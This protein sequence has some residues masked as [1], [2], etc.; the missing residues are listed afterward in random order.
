MY[1]FLLAIAL[2]MD[3]VAVCMANATK[4]AQIK[5]SSICLMAFIFGFFQA[6]MPVLGYFFGLGFYKFIAEIDHYIAF[7]ILVF[8]G[9]KM[10]KESKNHLEMDFKL[11]FWTLILG[12]IATS[13]DALAA[14]ITLGFESVNIVFAAF[15]IGVVCFVLCIGAGLIGKFLGQ[16]LQNKALILGGVILIILGFKILLEHLNLIKFV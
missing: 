15:M 11:G 5:F 3:S 1:L 10:I 7:F 2:S 13:I 8:L 6:F 9:F 4:H 16:N 14:G 12:A